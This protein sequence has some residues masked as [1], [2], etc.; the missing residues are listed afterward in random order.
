MPDLR[1][2]LREHDAGLIPALATIWKVDL[3]NLSPS[4]ALDTLHDAM[5]NTGK[6]EAVWEKLDE[7]A[8]GALQLLI[9]SNL[10]MSGSQFERMFG[11]IRKMGRGG[12]EKEQPH[13]KPQNVAEALFYR[14]FISTIFEQSKSGMRQV[15]YVP[16]DLVEVL[17]LHKTQYENI[18]D[19][20]PEVPE[21]VLQVYPL[22]EETDLFEVQPANTSIVDD[23][24]TL[25]AFL[26][27]EG[28][29]VIEDDFLPSDVE[30]LQP[31]L[32]DD[33]P[34]RL[35]F[36]L[37]VG[38]SADIITTQE[39]R[40][41]PKR[42]GLQKWLSA[43]RSAQIKALVDA[44][45]T[46][47]LY[48][49]LW[50]VSG[51]HPEDGFPYDPTIGRAALVEFLTQFVPHGDWWSL[52]ELIS[53]IKASEPDFQRPG[54]D[55]ESWYIRNDESEYL[56]GFES[57]EAIEGALLE[58]YLYG[59][60]HWLGLVDIAEDAAKLTAYGRAFI[61]LMAWPHRPDNNEKI[62]IQDDGILAVS[63][64]VARV[65]RFQVARFTTWGDA[66][67]PT[68]P[69][70]YRMDADGIQLGAEQGITTDHIA[71][72]LKRHGEGQQLPPVIARLLQ[73]WQG[74][75]STRVSFERLLVLRTTSPEALDRIYEAP[76]LRRYLGAKLGA[77]ACIIREGQETAL[78]DALG[79][80]G[81][82]VEIL[83]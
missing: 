23:M 7:K 61:E 15:V 66:T 29:G 22:D 28:A 49:D 72:F 38:I 60:M 26:R 31:Y 75:E 24:T 42:A 58:F 50:H 13:L 52:D 20:M 71:A 65:D 14:G 59:P 25:L 30:Q 21:V 19:E 63:R 78:R 43:S 55:Y 12:I 46:S 16:D 18:A 11:E 56:N 10:K 81:I 51:L 82:S 6:N 33:D 64:R 68:Q 57:W 40:A 36:L 79:E 37:G 9:S 70:Y 83:G 3:K 80:A 48:R 67:D 39:G 53:V 54:G 41:Y 17:P 34:V 47:T 62:V 1:T 8:R 45:K 35:N 76:A 2:T 77:M 27:I 73:T 5:L 69:Y 32:L 44:W 4:E 74:G